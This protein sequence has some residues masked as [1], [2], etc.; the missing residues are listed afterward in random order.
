MQALPVASIAGVHELLQG[1]LQLDLHVSKS[2]W[3]PACHWM[4]FQLSALNAVHP[5][6]TAANVLQHSA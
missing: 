5:K 4:Q 3:L 1:L 2:P 6:M